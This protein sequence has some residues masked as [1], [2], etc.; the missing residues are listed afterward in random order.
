M[1]STVEELARQ[2]AKAEHF[3]LM[4][5]YVTFVAHDLKNLISQLLLIL[6]QTKHH[7]HNPAF[8]NDSF[9]TI[10]DAV[11]KLPL[12]MHRV[13]AGAHT[14]PPVAVNLGTLLDHITDKSS[15]GHPIEPIGEQV[16]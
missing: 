10:G 7:V 11:E 16:A 8:V 2:V 1:A 13:R 14:V 15:D 6:Q 4:S 3:G 9:S 12:L 5:K